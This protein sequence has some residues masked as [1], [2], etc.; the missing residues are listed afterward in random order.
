MGKAFAL[1]NFPGV[2]KA[3]VGRATVVIDGDE[4]SSLARGS[5]L[6]LLGVYQ[7]FHVGR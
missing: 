1:P 7:L 2:G 4:V 5:F 6:W 3:A